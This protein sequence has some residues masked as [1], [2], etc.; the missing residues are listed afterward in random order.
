[1]GGEGGKERGRKGGK[2][3]EGERLSVAHLNQKIYEN[4][5]NL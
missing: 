1:M 5:Q 2:R 3:R 4:Y